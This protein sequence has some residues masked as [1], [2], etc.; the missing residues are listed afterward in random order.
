M[1]WN[2]QAT[3]TLRRGEITMSRVI[4]FFAGTRINRLFACLVASILLAA[5]NQATADPIPLIDLL[6]GD[7]FTVLDKVFTNWEATPSSSGSGFVDLA[8]IEVEGLDDDP[9][10]PGLKFNG[11]G[12]GVNGLGQTPG[13]GL[14]SLVL[15]FTVS[16]LSG[17]AIIKDNSLLINGFQFFGA[18]NGASENAFIQIDE[19][20]FDTEFESLGSKTVQVVPTDS[21]GDPSL[22]DSADF[23]PQSIIHVEKT[24]RVVGGETDVAVLDM[25]EQRFSQV[26]IPE[27]SS[28]ALLSFGTVM[29]GGVGWRRRRKRTR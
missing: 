21:P 7:S 19:V 13:P 18:S 12:V 23:F 17:D 27:P 8:A 14:A 6:E 2:L 10:N 3:R 29:L 26:A 25:F 24:I 15:S 16:T 1:E 5:P 28:L 20:I 22:S 9:L 4:H 11:S